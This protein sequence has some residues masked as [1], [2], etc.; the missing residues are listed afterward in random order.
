MFW[1]FVIE[2]NNNYGKAVITVNHKMAN[3]KKIFKFEESS[4][5][6]KGVSQTVQK[7]AHF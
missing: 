4:Q 6:G 2:L 1:L 7:W 5:I 3:L